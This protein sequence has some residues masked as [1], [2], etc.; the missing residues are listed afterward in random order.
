MAPPGLTIFVDLSGMVL[1][2]G[3]VQRV[4]GPRGA[5][6]A[7]ALYSSAPLLVQQARFGTVGMWGA[8]LLVAAAWEVVGRPVTLVRVRRAGGWVGLA[9]ARKPSLV[10]A[11]LIPMAA[12]TGAAGQ[13]GPAGRRP[14]GGCGGREACWEWP[15]RRRSSWRRRW[16]WRARGGGVDLPGA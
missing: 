9:T 14:P 10:V 11:L 12:M 2:M 15:P 6:L 3:V 16:C 1:P 5:G 8:T 7:G 13:R 4:A